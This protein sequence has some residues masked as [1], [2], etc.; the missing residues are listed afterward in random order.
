MDK[1]SESIAQTNLNINS[2]LI[3][4]LCESDCLDQNLGHSDFVDKW[5]PVL[6]RLHNVISLQ[7]VLSVS[8]TLSLYIN[9]I[10][11]HIV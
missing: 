2:Y 5:F 7:G 1:I 8:Q 11:P 3:Q 4:A 6:G 10:N 9:F